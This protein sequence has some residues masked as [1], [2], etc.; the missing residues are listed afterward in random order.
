MAESIPF[1]IKGD[2][3]GY[4]AMDV[5]ATGMNFYGPKGFFS[6]AMVTKS[7]AYEVMAGIELAVNRFGADNVT[8]HYKDPGKLPFIFQTYGN[9]GPRIVAAVKEIMGAAESGNE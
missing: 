2:I 6:P 8:I 7:V 5:C 4:S 1:N 9:A 3:V